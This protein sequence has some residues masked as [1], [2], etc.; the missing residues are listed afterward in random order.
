MSLIDTAALAATRPPAPAIALVDTAGPPLASALVAEMV[1]PL[2]ALIDVPLATDAW[3]SVFSVVY[4]SDQPTATAPA[5]KPP[6]VLLVL[7]LTFAV[8]AT[9]CCAVI[10][11]P[12]TSD[13]MPS[14]APKLAASVPVALPRL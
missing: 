4:A 10:V 9:P 12:L 13:W 14:L 8:I 1:M 2:P 6:A 7:L 3:I 5:A 11:P